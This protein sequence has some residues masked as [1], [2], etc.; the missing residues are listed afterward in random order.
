MTHRDF[1]DP[2]TGSPPDDD[3]TPVVAGVALIFVAIFLGALAWLTL[4]LFAKML[5]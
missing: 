3:A 4:K 2:V 1:D 5:S